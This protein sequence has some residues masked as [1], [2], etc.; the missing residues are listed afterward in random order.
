MESESQ[1]STRRVC[2]LYPPRHRVHHRRHHLHGPGLD[3]HDAHRSGGRVR[4]QSA[5][6]GDEI[7][8]IDFIVALVVEAI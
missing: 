4:F 5:L 1:L 6:G 2:E 3:R 8:A 7:E